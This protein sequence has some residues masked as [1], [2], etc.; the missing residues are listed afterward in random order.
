MEQITVSVRNGMFSTRV[1]TGGSGR[2]LVF[3]HG[4]GGLRPDSPYLSD[5]A[6]HFTLYAP[7]H[8]GFGDSEGIDHIDDVHDLATYYQD[9]FDALGLQGPAVVGHSFGG[10]IAA[11]IAAHCSASVGRLVLSAPVGLWR[12]D[13]PV[14]DIFT[15][16]PEETAA[17]AWHDPQG[18]LAKRYTTAPEDPEQVAI[19]TIDRTRALAAAGKFL[20]PI[21]DKGLKKRIHRIKAPT[22]IIWGASDKLVPAVY[23]QEFHS[24]IPGS[25]LL[26]VEQAGH[27]TPLEQQSQWVTAVR[28]FVERS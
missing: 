27:M 2:P 25:T 28:E 4:A 1:L 15:M 9:L 26:T 18:E 12:D 5:L 10:M 7:W 8:P 22:L 20:W 23:A 14:M 6:Q 17:A 24:R 3:L 19:A 21:P 16:S 11:E 13:A